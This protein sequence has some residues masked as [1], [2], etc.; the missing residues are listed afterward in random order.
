MT[1]QLIATLAIAILLVIGLIFSFVAALGLLK[2]NDAMMRLHAPTKAG[3][4]GTG[5]F[6][7][8]SMIHSYAFG[9]GSLH[10]LLIL[11]FLF[12][13]APASANFMARVNM[14]KR[15][16]SPPPTLPGDEMWSTLNVPEEDREI[17]EMQT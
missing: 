11:A 14:H 2:L 1:L 9:A 12:A 3:T 4:L 6:L 16:C 5:A 7:L 8:A 17:E 10:E 15:E 13:T